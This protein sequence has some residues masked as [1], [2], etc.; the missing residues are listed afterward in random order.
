V[1]KQV[2][3]RISEVHESTIPISIT[4]IFC[5]LSI[6][7]NYVHFRVGG[8]IKVLCNTFKNSTEEDEK[9]AALHALFNL[10]HSD[11]FQE[12]GKSDAWSIIFS[13]F[14]K[15]TKHTKASNIPYEKLIHTLYLL[16]DDT[17]Q[18]FKLAKSLTI[19]QVHLLGELLQCAIRSPYGYI[20]KIC[21]LIYQALH[22]R[23]K[24]SKMKK[25][26]SLVHIAGYK[27]RSWFQKC[28]FFSAIYLQSF[29]PI[30][31]HFRKHI[32]WIYMVTRASHNYENVARFYNQ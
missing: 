30:I 26:S 14:Y 18:C 7:E 21:A 3:I 10:I 19:H 5:D 2:A 32:G 15:F 11:N 23:N 16:K 22:F 13:E 6:P 25:F 20:G 9:E 4:K 24:F 8:L 28:N 17:N 1:N 27:K 29:F 31:E 12:L